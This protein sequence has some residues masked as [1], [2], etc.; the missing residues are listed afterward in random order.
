MIDNHS[1]VWWWSNENMIQ[2][3]KQEWWLM[4]KLKILES[5]R[6]VFSTCKLS[7]LMEYFLSKV[8]NVWACTYFFMFH[9]GLHSFRVL[10]N[11]W[12]SSHYMCI[13][14]K[15]IIKKICEPKKEKCTIVLNVFFFF[16]LKK[17]LI[18]VLIIWL[19]SWITS[20]L[21]STSHMISTHLYLYKC[22][23]NDIGISFKKEGKN[24][25]ICQIT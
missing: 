23:L 7:F 3:P 11:K 4:T 5:C 6:I 12:C 10:H 14:W 8:S 21:Y 1:W 13:I 24:L 2:T 25:H 15:E 9:C 22:V 20:L 17:I 18:C 16:G 19:S